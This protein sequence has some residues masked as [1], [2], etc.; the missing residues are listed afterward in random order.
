VAGG[1]VKVSPALAVREDFECEGLGALEALMTDG[2]RSLLTTSK[3][4]EM[5]E[6][7]LRYPGHADQME[8]FRETGLFSEEPVDV[9]GTP[10][11]P[12][13]L[14]ARLLFP[15]W[16]YEPG[17]EDLTVMRVEVDTREDG[18]LVR[19]TY[20]LLDRYDA[21][22]G[23]SSMART[24]GFTATALARRILSGEFARPGVSFPEHLGREPRCFKAILTD[25]GARGV[26]VESRSG[27]IPNRSDGG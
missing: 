18:R 14:T 3:V 9:S 7:T 17:E 22:T 13:E 2:L 19:H 15:I 12:L 21:D 8:L 11:V 16:R 25:L 20:D 24:T 5:R 1:E 6:M 4:P 23:L 26:R 10:V 27:F